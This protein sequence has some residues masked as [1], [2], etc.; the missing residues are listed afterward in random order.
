[1]VVSPRYVDVNIFV[2]W[3]GKHPTLGELAYKWVKEIENSLQVKYIT[4]SLTLYEVLVIM[5]G[6]TGK[7]LKDK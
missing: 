1:M 3:L 6:L 4:S 5:A 2:Y 7:S